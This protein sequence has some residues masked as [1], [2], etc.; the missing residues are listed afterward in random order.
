MSGCPNKDLKYGD[1]SASMLAGKLDQNCHRFALF[2]SPN[3]NMA[4]VLQNFL[5]L[6][7]VVRGERRVASEYKANLTCYSCTD[8]DYP[9]A[10]A[11]RVYVA[12]FSIEIASSS[13]VLQLLFVIF[14]PP[15]F[16]LRV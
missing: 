3:F 16:D 11:A 9:P 8:R 14:L 1:W 6:I 7:F 12:E 15:L 13:K 4:R 5:S 10:P 2:F